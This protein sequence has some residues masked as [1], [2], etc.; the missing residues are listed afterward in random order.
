MSGHLL[1]DPGARS[2]NDVEHT[3]WKAGL[4]SQFS[5]ADGAERGET[6]GLEHHGVSGGERG[7]QLPGRDHHREVPRNDQPDHAEWL[8]QRE[9]QSGLGNLDRFAEELVRRTGVVPQGVGDVVRLPPRVADRLPDIPGLQHRQ[10]LGVGP[11]QVGKPKAERR[12]DSP[13]SGPT[14][15]ERPSSRRPPPGPAHRGPPM[16]LRPSVCPWRAR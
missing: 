5:E 10:F 4:E 13:R 1:A 16:P 2:R 11:H 6:R 8:A 3:G 12:L 14:I 7:T 9:I 15:P